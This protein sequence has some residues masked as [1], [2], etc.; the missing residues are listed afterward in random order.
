M[1]REGGMPWM[2]AQTGKA[3]LALWSYPRLKFR[4]PES[5]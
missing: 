4:P 3:L 5:P 2:D 1:C